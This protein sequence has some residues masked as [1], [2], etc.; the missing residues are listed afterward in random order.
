M[1]LSQSW[2]WRTKRNRIISFVG[3]IFELTGTKHF[4]EPG[5]TEIT[6]KGRVL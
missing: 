2:H 6:L 4:N 1:P 5:E 3:E